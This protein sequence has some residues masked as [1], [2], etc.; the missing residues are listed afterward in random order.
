MSMLLAALPAIIATTVRMATPLLF[1]TLGELYS[2]RAGQVNIGLDG[3][4]AIGALVGF[5]VGYTTG[6]P[7]LGVLAAAVSG[8]AVNLIYAFCTLS[9]DD[10][11]IKS[12]QEY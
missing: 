4:M 7:W 9:L 11:D 2:E 10:L 1:V 3:L 12:W 6:S 5:L 8:I